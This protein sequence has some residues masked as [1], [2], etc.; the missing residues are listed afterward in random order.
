MLKFNVSNLT[1]GPNVLYVTSDIHIRIVQNIKLS[2]IDVAN[3]YA[4][5]E[6]CTF[7]IKLAH[8]DFQLIHFLRRQKYFILRIKAVSLIENLVSCDSKLPEQ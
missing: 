6:I 8:V 1:L 2:R 3:I 5:Y 4:K 7:S